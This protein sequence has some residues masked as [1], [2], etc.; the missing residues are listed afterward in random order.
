MYTHTHT[1]RANP[2][3]HSATHHHSTQLSSGLNTLHFKSPLPPVTVVPR[4]ALNKGVLDLARRGLQSPANTFH[5][6]RAQIKALPHDTVQ[7]RT[8]L[9]FCSWS[10]HRRQCEATL[11]RG[12]PSLSSPFSIFHFSPSSSCFH[13]IALSIFPSRSLPG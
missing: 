9:C 12:D 8:G 5:T 2:N 3:S 6:S 4:F 11:P 1:L 7:T 10:S 13:S